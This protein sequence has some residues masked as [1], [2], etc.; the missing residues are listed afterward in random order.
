[1]ICSLQIKEEYGSVLGAQVQLSSR[2]TSPLS[3]PIIYADTEPCSYLLKHTQTRLFSRFVRERY[4]TLPSYWGA[5]WLRRPT[6]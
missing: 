3:K 1:M 6:T 4:G 2:H 5:F